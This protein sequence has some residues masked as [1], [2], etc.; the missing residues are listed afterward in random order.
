[1]LH[2]GQCTLVRVAWAELGL[3]TSGRDMLEDWLED[4]MED[5]REDWPV[6]WT[7]A[8]LRSCRPCAC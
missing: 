7:R 2:L 4:W 5:W 8:V 1:M 6:L 3:P